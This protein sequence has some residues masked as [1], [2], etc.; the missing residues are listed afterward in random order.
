MRGCV[1]C[2]RR[3]IA[4]PIVESYW[5]G[6]ETMVFEPLDPVVPGHLLVVPKYHA[7]NACQSL[8]ITAA[9]A[10]VAA[11]VARRYESANLITSIGRAATQSVMHLH[12][13]VVPR[14][15]GDG[16]ALPWGAT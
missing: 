9:A 15:A 13:H 4:S 7:D 1:F 8:T 5:G 10:A 6:V 16:L 2:E 12:T 11:R 14:Q 3:L